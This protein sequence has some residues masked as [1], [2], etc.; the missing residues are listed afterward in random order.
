MKNQRG[1]SMWEILVLCIVIVMLAIGGLKVTPAYIEYFKIKKA[2][3]GVAQS[4]EARGT[5]SD[6]R[7]AFDR[8]AVIDDIDAVKAQDLEITKEGNEVVISFTYSKKIP[9]FGPLSLWFDFTG[10]SSN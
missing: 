7:K 9:L 8:R 2:V 6:I 4:G 10:S 5:V 3:A 1:M